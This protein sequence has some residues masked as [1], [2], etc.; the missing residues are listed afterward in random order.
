MSYRMTHQRRGL[1]GAAQRELR[2]N[3]PDHSA[4]ILVARTNLPH[5]SVS[6][7]MSW[8]NSAGEPASG[9]APRSASCVFIFGSARPALISLFS[10][11]TISAVVFLGAP[12]PYETLA[13]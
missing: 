8:P 7:A 6:S 11:S 4:L 1:V 5:F 2:N 12:T 9:V 10:L 3:G 13:S